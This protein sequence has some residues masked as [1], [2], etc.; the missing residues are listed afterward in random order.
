M[1][2]FLKS[3]ILKLLLLFLLHN[4]I[5]EPAEVI[6]LLAAEELVVL[7]GLSIS[8][9]GRAV[10][11]YVGSLAFIHQQKQPHI[12]TLKR[13]KTQTRKRRSEKLP[14]VPV[15]CAD[16]NHQ[17][18]GALEQFVDQGRKERK[19][20]YVEHRVQEFHQDSYFTPSLE[21]LH[22]VRR[23]AE[24]RFELEFPED[25]LNVA[26]DSLPGG[27]ISLTPDSD[28]HGVDQPTAEIIPPPLPPEQDPDKEGKQKQDIDTSSPEKKVRYPDNKDKLR[29]NWCKRDGHVEKTS[30]YEKLVEDIANDLKCLLGSP[31]KRGHRWYGKILKD[32]RQAWVEV[33]GDVMESWGISEPG[34]IRT[35]NPET[36]LKAPKAPSQ[37]I[38]KKPS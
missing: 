22:K 35:Y 14:S 36:G 12:S 25:A 34:K 33:R 28:S 8:L 11:H 10:S 26:A 13:S 4:T 16:N 20:A 15:K 38:P 32:G 2:F 1:K 31:D 18:Y 37:Q 3:Y 9:V 27:F 29:H 30:E 6:A 21:Q 19:R 5:T 24:E 7:T 23:E 17:S